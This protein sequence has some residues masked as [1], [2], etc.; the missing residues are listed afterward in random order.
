MH[1]CVWWYLCV[2]TSTVQSARVH[3]DLPSLVK[4]SPTYISSI[5]KQPRSLFLNDFIQ[6]RSSVCMFCSNLANSNLTNF[7]LSNII[8]KKKIKTGGGVKKIIQSSINIT[9]TTNPND[10]KSATRVLYENDK[11]PPRAGR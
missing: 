4:M 10:L 11:K 9:R 3:V 7:Q 2:F 5:S 6:L 8:F 1:R